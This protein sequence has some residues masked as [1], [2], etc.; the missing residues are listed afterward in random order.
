MDVLFRTACFLF[1]L[2]CCSMVAT[3]QK[4]TISGKVTDEL[5]KEP[6]IAASVLVKGTAIGAATDVDGVFKF[7]IDDTSEVTLVITYVGYEDKEIVLKRPFQFVNTT[8]KNFVIQGD[9]VVVTGSRVSEAIIESGTTI[10]K[11]DAKAIK[12][13]PSGNFYAGLSVLP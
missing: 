9:Q 5:S 4:V 6:L 8:L 11:I 7:E 1:S 10:D 3:A 13:A 12:T 2:S